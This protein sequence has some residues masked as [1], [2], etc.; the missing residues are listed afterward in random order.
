VKR[1]VIDLICKGEKSV[2]R[3]KVKL[4]WWL[5]LLVSLVNYHQGDKLQG[6]PEKEYRD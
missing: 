4:V 6:S 3:K 2:S 5:V 1:I